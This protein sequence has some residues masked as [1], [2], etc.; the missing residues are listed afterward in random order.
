MALD[1][2]TGSI[3]TL[4]EAQGYVA[5]FRALYPDEVKAFFVGANKIN[6]IL[7]QTNCIGIR[8]YNGYDEEA[9][10]MNQVLVGVDNN[11]QDMSGGVIV[12]KLFPCPKYCDELSPLY[13]F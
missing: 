2:N 8:I 4:T 12:E 10:T 7:E 6:S 11:E 3:I 9:G 1:A 13:D 5:A